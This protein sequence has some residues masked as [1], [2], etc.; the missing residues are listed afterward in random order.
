[1]GRQ[2]DGG[3]A[4]YTCVP[5]GQ[6][7][8]IKTKLSWDVLG[9]LPEMVQTAWGSLFKSL[10]IRSGET[11]LIRGATS[12]V[13]LA[14]AAISKNH[15]VKVFGTSRRKGKEDLMKR[16]GIEEVFIDDGKLAEKVRQAHPEGVDKV[17]QL[18]PSDPDGNV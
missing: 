7:Q 17:F 18:H 4:E 3:Y 13:G 14:A 16:S 10:R 12:S 11:L 8:T 6:V 9:A 15:G 5:A 1:M 2:F